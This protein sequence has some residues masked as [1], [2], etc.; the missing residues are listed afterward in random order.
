MAIE[1]Y[2]DEPLSPRHFAAE[3]SAFRQPPA[4]FFGA[5]T[6]LIAFIAE[7]PFSGCL[8]F[9]AIDCITPLIRQPLIAMTLSAAADYADIDAIITPPPLLIR[10]ALLPQ[11]ITFAFAI[12]AALSP[13]CF[14]RFFRRH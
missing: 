12:F 1:P 14:Q 7:P 13:C 6:P 3:M 8:L 10:D 2:Y 4:D 9:A 5:A 11:M